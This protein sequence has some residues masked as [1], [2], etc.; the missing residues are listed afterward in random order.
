[1]V[2]AASWHESAEDAVAARRAESAGWL[3]LA[4]GLRLTS[5][6]VP[7]NSAGRKC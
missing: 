3:C 2:H 7:G 5:Y 4:P 6:I 1:M